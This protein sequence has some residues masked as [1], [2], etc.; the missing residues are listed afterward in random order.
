MNMR[1]VWLSLGLL[2]LAIGLAGV[3]LPLVPATVFMVIA[4]WA[5]GKSSPRL[6]AWILRHR[7]IG[8]PV[9]DWRDHGVIRRRAKVFATF[10][11]ALSVLLAVVIQLPLVLLGLQASILAVVT[12]FIWTRPEMP[13]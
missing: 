11:I 8:P 2:A 4:A 13:R 9:V 10:G 12:V 7:H 5:F 1:H 3:L 6:Q